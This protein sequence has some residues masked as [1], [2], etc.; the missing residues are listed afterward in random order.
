MEHSNSGVF[1]D[2]VNYY[3]HFSSSLLPPFLSFS[4][5]FFY[6]KGFLFFFSSPFSPSCPSPSPSSSFRKVLMSPR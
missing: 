4:S 5:S 2:K 3:I 6:F 1:F